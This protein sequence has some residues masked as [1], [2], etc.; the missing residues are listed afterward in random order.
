[1]G[2]FAPGT[3]DVVLRSI[4]WLIK[5]GLLRIVRENPR[6]SAGPK[7]DIGGSTASH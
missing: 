5:I 3:R 7:N 1:V 2:S 4:H 6:R